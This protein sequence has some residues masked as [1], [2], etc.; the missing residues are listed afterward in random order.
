MRADRMP[1]GKRYWPAGFTSSLIASV[2]ESRKRERDCAGAEAA[3]RRM[4]SDSVLSEMASRLKAGP[5]YYTNTIEDGEVK[6]DF[7]DLIEI[8]HREPDENGG[9]RY[10]SEWFPD[11]MK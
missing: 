10:Y 6:T 7:I 4:V 2:T 9:I 11:I 8:F 1:T 3:V 5:V